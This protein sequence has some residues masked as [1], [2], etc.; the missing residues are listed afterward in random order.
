MAPHPMSAKSTNMDTKSLKKACLE[1]CRDFYQYL[2]DS[3]Y[4]PDDDGQTRIMGVAKT[5]VVRWKLKDGYI[6]LHTA[7]KIVSDDSGL[8]LEINGKTFDHEDVTFNQVDERTQSAVIYP[9]DR[10]WN[11]FLLAEPL[12]IYVISDMKWLVKLTQSYIESYGDRL[13][14]PPCDPHFEPSEC[15]SPM[16][17]QPTDQQQLAV[18]IV[19]NSRLS[20]VW[21]APGTGKTQ[22]VLTNAILAYLRRGGKVLVVA[23]TNNSLEQVLRGLLRSLAQ[24]DP[25]G[26]LV[27]L[28]HDI[29]RAGTATA[30]FVHDYPDICEQSGITRQVRAKEASLQILQQV[31]FERDCDRLKAEFDEIDSLFGQEY[32]CADYLAKRRIMEQVMTYLDEIKCIVDQNPRLADVAG[33]IDEYNIRQAAP[34]IAA[35]LYNRPRPAKEIDEYQEQT[36]E[37]LSAQTVALK[38]ELVALRTLEPTA[39]AETAHIVAATPQSFM[40]RF[41]PPGTEPL[42]GMTV[43]PVNH[44]FIDE[45]GYCNVIQCLPFFSFGAP[46]TMLGDHMQLPPVC[47]ASN[48]MLTASIK[49]NSYCRYVFMW[50][51]MVLF[52]EAYLSRDIAEAAAAFLHGEE[53]QLEITRK[54]DLT[55]SHRFGDNLARVLDECVY[56]NGIR[57]AGSAA[58]QIECLDCHNTKREANRDNLAEAEAIGIYLKAHPLEPDT[59]VI[60]TP[61]TDQVKLLNRLYTELKENILTVHRSQG[62]EWDTVILSVADDRL[63]D[64]PVPLRF[65][66]TV[67]PESIGRKVINTAVSRAKKRLVLV[68]DKEFWVEKEG[69]LIGKLAAQA[70]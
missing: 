52:A 34:A 62:R 6:L 47:E 44:I 8:G 32:D 16:V 10:L 63:Q 58:L 59:F 35:Q 5:E 15:M 64:R 4:I 26:K 65:T 60:V 20:Y 41:A 37:D 66:S 49:S 36:D 69:E 70:E 28:K 23:P 27:D 51:Q 33:N 40:K 17:Q 42:E 22:Y 9:S 61:Y 50:A 56:R 68:C 39:R 38:Q 53:P 21:G 48:E 3:Q 25:K 30:E 29:F 55:L 13:A 11:L 19:L 54:V 12:K 2:E 18:S 57:G 31:L 67:D 14:L 46:V 43:L 1:S 45:A 24:I 7:G